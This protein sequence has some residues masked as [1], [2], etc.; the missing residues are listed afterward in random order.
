MATLA[1]L[2]NNSELVE[3]KN[4]PKLRAV[5]NVDKQFSDITQKEMAWIGVAIMLSRNDNAEDSMPN[6]LVQNYASDIL[7]IRA[8][9]RRLSLY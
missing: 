9:Q 6:S 4:H 7:A 5:I 1:E 3:I 8:M 2:L